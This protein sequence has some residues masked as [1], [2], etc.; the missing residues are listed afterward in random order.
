[1]LPLHILDELFLASPE[2][3]VHDA[4]LDGA[5]SVPDWI[6]LY[7][8]DTNDLVNLVSVVSNVTSEGLRTHRLKV[9]LTQFVIGFF[10][11][12]GYQCC[13]HRRGSN[14]LHEVDRNN[15]PSILLTNGT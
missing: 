12:A 9:P 13:R 8:T 1:D 3:R 15:L 2:G 14:T 7:V 5:T 4:Q 6:D 10:V 11:S